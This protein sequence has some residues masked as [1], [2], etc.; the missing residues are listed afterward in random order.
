MWTMTK[1]GFFSAVQH[2]ANLNDLL[3]RARSHRDLE[4]LLKFADN[5]QT[6]PPLEFGKIEATIQGA[7]YP[8]RLVCSKRAWATVMGAMIG[9]VD[10]D[11]FKTQVART[12]VARAHTYGVVWQVLHDVE[13]EPG[14]G[15]YVDDWTPTAR[16]KAKAVKKPST[17]INGPA[18]DN[19]DGAFDDPPLATARPKAKPS[20]KRGSKP[21]G[22]RGSKR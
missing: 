18:G 4:N 16:P 17:P 2:R 7:D 21:S 14:A 22:K 19:W 9:D 20:G 11:N 15:V 8:Y 5:V 12:N 3:I 6:K 1:I 10:Y 13:H